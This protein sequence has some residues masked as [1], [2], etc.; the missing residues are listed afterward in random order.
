MD[1]PKERWTW[2]VHC[3]DCRTTKSLPREDFAD[4]AMILFTCD[5]C[6]FKKEV[7]NPAHT[8]D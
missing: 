8:T 3:P 1:K 5:V 4:A 6:G 7:D 2:S